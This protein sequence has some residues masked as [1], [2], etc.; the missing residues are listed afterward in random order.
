MSDLVTVT[1]DNVSLDVSQ[2]FLIVVLSRTM[3]QLTVMKLALP[4]ENLSLAL[5]SPK[6]LFSI[7][8]IN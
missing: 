6:K 3:S 5:L 4:R 2:N 8:R 7:L 1:K